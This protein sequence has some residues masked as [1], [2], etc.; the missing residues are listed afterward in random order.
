MSRN[1]VD[2]L[3]GLFLVALL[4]WAVWEAQDWRARTR[5]FPWAIGFPVL[6][7]SA[8][9]LGLSVWTAMRPPKPEEGREEPV[10]PA[11]DAEPPLAPGLVRRR[12]LEISAWAVA[13]A[14]GLWLLGFKVGGLVLSP[15]FLRF[16]ARETWT[17]S[18]VYGFGV[19]LFFFAGLETALAFPLPPGLIAR[20]LG[21]Q[22]FD[23]Y[24]VD[25][26]LDL[27]R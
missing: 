22:S 14:L 9:H 23:S 16:Q 3:I 15:A 7:L 21:L 27:F 11:A 6:A 4:A 1:R 24:L 10:E 25:P 26:V 13:F 20:S 18:L 19:Y 5:F 12:T 17:T 8:V 2:I